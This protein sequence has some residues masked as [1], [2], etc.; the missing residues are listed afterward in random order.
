MNDP[1]RPPDRYAIVTGGG[2]GLG[3]EFCRVFA[4]EGY[5]VAIVGLRHDSLVATLHLVESDG[6]TGRVEICDVTDVAAWHS[7]RDRLRAEWPR[8]DLLINNAGMFSNGFVGRLDFAEVERLLRLNLFGA[9]YG[10]DTFVPWLIESAKQTSGGMRPH[11]VNVSSIYAF[12]SPPGMSAYNISKAGVV[13]LSET[14]RGELAPYGVGVTV[15]CPG[16]MPTRFIESAQFESHAYR[17]LAESF[18]HES[19]LKPHDV[20]EAVLLA[21]RRNELFCVMGRPERWYWRLKN[22]LPRTVLKRVAKRVRRDLKSH[23]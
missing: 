2:S 13:S 10:C 7:L 14:L 6:G 8:L 16:P 23:S 11:V 3:R 15:V 17:R 18:V 21:V 19:T 4:K 9:I 22:W 1:T 5:C 20:A 12:L